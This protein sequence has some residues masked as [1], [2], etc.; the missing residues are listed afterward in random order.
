MMK[1]ERKKELTSLLVCDGLKG[2]G[3]KLGVSA[4]AKRETA[5]A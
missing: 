1:R 4:K 5:A 2:E 3:R